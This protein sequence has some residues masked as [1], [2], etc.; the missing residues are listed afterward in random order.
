MGR[1]RFTNKQWLRSKIG[2]CASYVEI[3]I[4]TLIV[5][6]ILLLSLRVIGDLRDI[7][8]AILQ[9]KEM[10]SIQAFLTTALEL[11]IGIEFVKMLAKHTPSSAVEVLLYAIAR[12]IIVEHVTITDALVGIV[13]IAILFSIRRFLSDTVFRSDQ[14]EFIVNGAMSVSEIND[15][16]G[17]TIDENEGRTAAGIISKK[18]DLMNH[19]VESGYSVDLDNLKLQVYTMDEHLIKQIKIVTS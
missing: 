12:Q 9:G 1:S 7:V 18:A 6:G 19:K 11:I 5:V 2:S 10:P 4:S 3:F 14:N 17:L 8:T 16:L 15:Q 13:A